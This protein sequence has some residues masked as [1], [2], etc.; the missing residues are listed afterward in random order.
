MKKIK[1]PQL[2]RGDRVIFICPSSPVEIESSRV[3]DAI[4]YLESLGLEVVLGTSCY[5]KDSY[6][7]G[8]D[9]IRL[10]DLMSAFYRQDIQGIFCLKGGY[11]ATRIVDKIDYQIIRENPKLFM[12]FSDITVLL[13]SIYQN[14][15]LVTAHGLVGTFMS[16]PNCDSFSRRNFENF[17]FGSLKSQVFIGPNDDWQVLNKGQVKGEL[18]GGNLSLI[19]SL[20]GTDYDIDFNG[21]IV[22]IED[23]NE[24]PYR[25][26]RML[27]SL[28]LAKK[29]HQAKGFILGTFS[30]CEADGDGKTYQQVIK[31]YFS[32]LK[33]PTIYNFAC[34]HSFPFINLPIGLEIAFNASKGSVQIL[35]NMYKGDEDNERASEG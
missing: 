24:S 12:G 14:A 9:A 22:F 23:V 8:S 18:V 27:S 5:H 33:K 17:I 26:D 11:G 20:L 6:L 7:A 4:K 25:L 16:H 13:N 1:P 31:E 29:L 15:G 35:E 21:K 30:G 3:R 34:G 28:K 10:Q 32:D 19:V 2:K